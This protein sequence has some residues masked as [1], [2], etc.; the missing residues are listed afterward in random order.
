MMTI[1]IAGGEGDCMLLACRSLKHLHPSSLS[2][3]GSICRPA[4]RELTEV[5]LADGGQSRQEQPRHDARQ[6][7][8]PRQVFGEAADELMLVE[9]DYRRLAGSRQ[10]M[11]E[12]PSWSIAA[13][14]AAV[15]R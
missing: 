3:S 5:G 7:T 10:S 1:L 4:K 8:C 11:N 9:R 15:D 6:R 14:V 12:R 2:A 13:P